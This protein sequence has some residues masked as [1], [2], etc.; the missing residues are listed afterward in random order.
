[1]VSKSFLFEEL[2]RKYKYRRRQPPSD[3]ES[4][5]GYF[6]VGDGLYGTEDKEY[7][8]TGITKYSRFSKELKQLYPSVVITGAVIY[9]FFAIKSDSL[10]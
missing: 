2:L 3:I 9:G 6:Y 10:K 7:Y 4:E 5:K 1:M 8:K